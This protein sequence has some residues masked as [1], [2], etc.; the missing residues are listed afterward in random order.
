MGDK[1]FT[2]K[3]ILRIYEAGE[4]WGQRPFIELSSVYPQALPLISD[5]IITLT[6]LQNS[7]HLL[8]RFVVR[9]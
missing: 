6:L 4:N 2:Q 7:H 8:G 9:P 5:P 3:D 1:L